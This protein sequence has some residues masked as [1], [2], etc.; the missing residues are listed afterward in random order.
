MLTVCWAAKGGSGT[1]VTAVAMA[2]AQSRPTLLVDLAGDAPLV[3]GVS[4][5]DGP[6]LGDWLSSKAAADRLPRLE[7]VVADGTTMIP[8]GRPH[9][10]HDT[11]A[12]RWRELAEHLGDDRRR[13]IVDAGT[14]EPPTP[15]VER[16]DAALLVTRPCYL[17]MTRA[18]AQRVRPT[19]VVMIDEPGRSI[20]RQDI[21]QALGAPVVATILLDPR[22]ARAADAGLAAARLP[23]ACLA[24]LRSAA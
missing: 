22:I 2:L 18:R 20:R 8:A 7:V 9:P 21:E 1:T 23:R 6:G 24:Q 15:L 13:V 14:G 11:P 5:G 16:A 4:G 12:P 19:G 3:A 17:S 10:P